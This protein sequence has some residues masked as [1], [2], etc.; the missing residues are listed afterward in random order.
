MEDN[1]DINNKKMQEP[2]FDDI[3]NEKEFDVCKVLKNLIGMVIDI[4]ALL[5]NVCD[6]STFCSETL[7]SLQNQIEDYENNLEDEDL[8]GDYIDEDNDADIEED[9]IIEPK[10]PKVFK[11]NYEF[12]NNNYTQR[13]YKKSNYKKQKKF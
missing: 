5:C 1:I 6:H 3:N 8:S 10:T 9:D 4:K 7:K 2:R 13:S 12:D 11:K